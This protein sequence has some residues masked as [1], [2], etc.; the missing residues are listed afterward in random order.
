MPPI[1]KPIPPN[2]FLLADHLDS[3]LASADELLAMRVH[4]GMETRGDGA[5]PASAGLKSFVD[6]ARTL[7]MSILS[8]ALQARAR[9][10]ELR[11]QPAHIR[12]LLSLFVSGTAPLA[13]AVEDLADRN[14][15]D[16]QTGN[17]PLAYLRSRGVITADHGSLL[18]IVELEIGDEFLIAKRIALGPFTDLAAQFLE[19][20][21][22]CY[23]LF[24]SAAILSD[25][26][27]DLDEVASGA[28][29]ETHTSRA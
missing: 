28:T 23:D 5:E 27:D 18:G 29:A 26:A 19:S 11:G 9:A 14:Y 3:V 8:R 25:L 1:L 17:C 20:L 12:P 15:A 10:N 2:V 16:F 4:V 21:T 24:R 7:E 6:R 22:T 13:D